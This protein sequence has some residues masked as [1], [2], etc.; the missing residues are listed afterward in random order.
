MV[1]AEYGH[2]PDGFS[3]CS[4]IT[5]SFERTYWS[6]RAA[7]GQTWPIRAGLNSTINNVCHPGNERQRSS[8]EASRIKVERNGTEE[9]SEAP[10]AVRRWY[11]VILPTVV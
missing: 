2:M 5:V 6:M 10:T 9:Q 11:L 1:L 8:W 3:K 7:T 4:K